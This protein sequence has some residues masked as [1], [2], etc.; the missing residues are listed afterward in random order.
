MLDKNQTI[1]YHLAVRV[2]KTKRFSRLAQK[3]EITDDELLSIVTNVL[4]KDNAD[5]NLGGEVFKVRIARENEGKSSGYRVILFFRKGERTFFQY[6]FPKSEKD[7]IDQKELRNYKKLARYMLS[8]TDAEISGQ[9][10]E[11]NIQE[12]ER[13]QP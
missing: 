11:G 1:Y 13:R 9:L 12:I 10:K 2:F 5:A 3:E 6:L 4:E 8:M 7:N